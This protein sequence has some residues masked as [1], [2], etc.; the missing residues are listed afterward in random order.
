[1]MFSLGL[2]GRELITMSPAGHITTVDLEH[3]AAQHSTS[4]AQGTKLE[5]G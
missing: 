4:A 5:Q 2:M 3:T 1:M